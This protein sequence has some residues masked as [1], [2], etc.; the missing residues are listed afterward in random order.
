LG[1][2]AGSL[3]AIAAVCAL[4]T[5]PEA[6]RALNR[7]TFYWVLAGIAAMLGTGTLALARRAGWHKEA[8]Q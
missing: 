8:S 2:A 4:A 1:Q 3:L 6:S 7:M 5:E